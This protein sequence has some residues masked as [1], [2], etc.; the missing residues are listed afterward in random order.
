MRKVNGEEKKGPLE[1]ASW[2]RMVMKPMKS[3]TAQPLQKPHTFYSRVKQFLFSSTSETFNIIICRTP[4]QEFGK[5]GLPKLLDL[6]FCPGILD[7]QTTFYIFQFYCSAYKDMDTL[8][9]TCYS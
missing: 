1:V 4:S 5:P 3:A 2:T 7:V 6:L 9:L 8:L